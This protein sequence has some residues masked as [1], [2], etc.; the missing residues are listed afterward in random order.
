MRAAPTIVPPMAASRRRSRLTGLGVLAALWGLSVLAGCSSSPERPK[1]TPLENPAPSAARLEPA[2]SQR[3]TAAVPAFRLAVTPQGLAAAGADGSV[4][5]I[6]AATGRDLWRGQVGAE[7]ASGVGSD[8]R[9]AAVVTRGG[10][11]VVLEGGQVRWRQ[12][13]PSRVVTVP[14][15]AGERVFVHATDRSVH[16]YDVQTGDR[17]W[18]QQRPGDPLT[19]AQPGVLLAV[20]N[21]LVVGQG[22]R[23]VGLDP[24][25]GSVSWDVQVAAPRGTNEVERLADLVGPAARDGD[26]VCVRAFQSSV[27]CVDSGREAL[28]WARNSSGSVGLGIDAASVYGVDSTDR[29]TAYRRATG[30]P[31]WTAEQFRFRGLTAPLAVAA[32]VVAGDAEGYVHL[33]S[34]DGGRSLARVATDGS[35]VIAPPVAVGGL[36]VVQTRSGGLFAF[37]LP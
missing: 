2:W 12:R 17:L 24:L 13:L 3:I 6:D 8:G 31:A 11:L 22:A 4:A 27:A 14:L 35:A 37:R 18:S 7:L 36:V 20:R 1:P 19:L 33:L 26:T 34:R 28:A 32:G 16:A 30:E 10:E 21:T 29:I 15:V 23:L 25:R 5:L 9:Y